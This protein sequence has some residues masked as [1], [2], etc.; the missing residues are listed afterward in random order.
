MISIDHLEE[1]KLHTA[2]D[3]KPY[4][5]KDFVMLVPDQ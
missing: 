3:D 4:L 1:I 5:V 2:Y